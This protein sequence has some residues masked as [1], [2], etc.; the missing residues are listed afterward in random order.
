M[1][2]KVLDEA[3][4]YLNTLKESGTIIGTIDFDSEEYLYERR[5]DKVDLGSTKG[6][7]EIKV[8]PNEGINYP[9]FHIESNEG[10]NESVCIAIY[11]AEYYI[12]SHGK[13]TLNSKEIKVLNK[14]LDK[15]SKLT[16][17]VLNDQ[18]KKVDVT[19]TNWQYIALDYDDN[20]GTTEFNLKRKKPEYYSEMP[21]MKDSKN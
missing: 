11:K 5:I 13:S 6:T 16:I 7:C 10:P 18:G 8:F 14:W 1:N 20:N 9:H 3:L 17:K 21:D 15:K 4:E 12:H 19:L 2:Y